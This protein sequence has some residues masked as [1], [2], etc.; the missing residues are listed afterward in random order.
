MKKI[1]LGLIVFFCSTIFVACDLQNIELTD[2]SIQV[3]E[4]IENGQ[5]N[6]KNSAKAGEVITIVFVPNDGFELEEGSLKYNDNEIEN[7]TFT[8]PAENVVISARFVEIVKYEI[9]ISSSIINGQI[10]VDKSM[11]KAGENVTVTVTPNDGF[12]LKSGSLKYSDD[13]T[14][15]LIE[16]NSFVMPSHYVVIYATFE[17]IK[18]TISVKDTIENGQIIIYR[19]LKA[20]E[21]ETINIFVTPDDGYELEPGTLKYNN[22]LIEGTSFKMPKENVV[23]YANFRQKEYDVKVSFTIK[24][25]KV[26]VN[27]TKAYEGDTITLQIEANEGYV[28]KDGS[29]TLEIEPSN[30]YNLH[31]TTIIKPIEGNQFTMPKRDVLVKCEFITEWSYIINK[32]YAKVDEID[33]SEAITSWAEKDD[34]YIGSRILRVAIQNGKSYFSTKSLAY[35]KNPSETSLPSGTMWVDGNNLTVNGY[36]TYS[37]STYASSGN[38][39]YSYPALH[40][41]W[42]STHRIFNFS[43]EIIEKNFETGHFVLDGTN[44]KTT[45]ENWLPVEHITYNRVNGERVESTITTYSYE[46]I[47]EIPPIPNLKWRKEFLGVTV[48]G[49]D[50]I[51]KDTASV[52]VSDFV[53]HC[54]NTSYSD[55]TIL[56]KPVRS[57][58][59][60]NG[61]TYYT[62]V[63]AFNNDGYCARIKVKIDSNYLYNN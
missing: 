8:M 49:N 27:K 63:V 14:Y 3:N 4:T 51:F 36:P 11:A 31:E 54:N 13:S 48:T 43:N 35:L 39:S 23:I 28:F 24:N 60:G 56:C 9:A 42:P 33:S 19:S 17:T 50:T 20:E 26:T 10:T 32:V 15:T 46:D 40:Y 6:V 25:G 16:N 7:N 18:Y 1:L 52:D 41:S 47:D 58:D 12:E 57:Y 37:Y 44:G 55:V 34:G 21:G 62:M 22:N 2:Y 30:D 45:I 61:F 5:I 38:P 29:L 59:Y 53:V